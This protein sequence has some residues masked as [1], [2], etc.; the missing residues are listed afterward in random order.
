MTSQQARSMGYKK[1]KKNI[2]EALKNIESLYF[3]G[4]TERFDES[5]ELLRH[6]TGWKNINRYYFNQ[7]DNY[8]PSLTE[9]INYRLEKISILDDIIYEHA[10]SC[11]QKRYSRFVDSN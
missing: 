3:I 8:E 2:D 7:A 4:I 6:Y 9:Y 10:V 1:T 11:F 5:A